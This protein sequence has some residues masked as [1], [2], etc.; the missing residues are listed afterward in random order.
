MADQSKKKVIKHFWVNYDENA[1]EKTNN[2]WAIMSIY[3]LRPALTDTTG[4]N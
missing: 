1:G 3:T 4:V 2:L